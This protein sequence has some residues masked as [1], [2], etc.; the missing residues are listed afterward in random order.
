MFLLKKVSL[1]FP[2]ETLEVP[3]SSSGVFFCILTSPAKVAPLEV[4][5][6]LFISIVEPSKT[7][8]LYQKKM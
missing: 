3:N 5:I 2:V 4:F 6:G 8:L 7:M 1:E